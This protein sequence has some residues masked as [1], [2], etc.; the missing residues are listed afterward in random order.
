MINSYEK[1]LNKIQKSGRNSIGQFIPYQG[2]EAAFNPESDLKELSLKS[3]HAMKE[4]H[5]K[6]MNLEDELAI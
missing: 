1:E 5:S 2:K 6:M 4:I 3:M